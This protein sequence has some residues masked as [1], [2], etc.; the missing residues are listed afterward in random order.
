MFS[1]LIHPDVT[2]FLDKLTEKERRR[3]VEAIRML[4]VDPFTSRSRGTKKTKRKK[5]DD[6]SEGWRF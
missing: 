5:E 1:V 4:K 2:R 3:C 6:V